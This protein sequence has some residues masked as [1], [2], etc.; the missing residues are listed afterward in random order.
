[1]KYDSSYS[2]DMDNLEKGRENQKNL[3]DD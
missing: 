3:V 1:V 2:K